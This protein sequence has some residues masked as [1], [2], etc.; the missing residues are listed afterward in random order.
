MGIDF[1]SYLPKKEQERMERL[2]HGCPQDVLDSLEV[3]KVPKGKSIMRSGTPCLYIYI[4]LRG[5]AQGME[6]HLEEKVYIFRSFTSGRILGELE[7]FLDQPLYSATIQAVTLCTLARIPISLWRSWIRQD[8]SLLYSRA[9]NIIGELTRQ[10]KDGRQYLF[11]SCYDRMILFLLELFQTDDSPDGFVLKKTRPEL[12]ELLGFCIK[13]VNRT[14]SQLQEDGLLS[15]R[16]GK[17]RLSPKQAKQMQEYCDQ[18]F[19]SENAFPIK[20]PSGSRPRGQ[21]PSG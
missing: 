15:V 21:S 5:R 8:S 9:Q 7:C 19:L 18:H 10:L 14:I 11:L 3:T 16:Q 1:I 6:M 2:F 12:A 13:T 4:I 17:I 20:A